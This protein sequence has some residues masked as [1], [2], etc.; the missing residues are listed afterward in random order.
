MSKNK[1]PQTTDPSDPV[2]MYIIIRSSLNLRM[3]KACAQAGHAV[4]S[5]M[6]NMV[7]KPNPQKEYVSLF[8]KWI[9]SDYRKIVLQ[10]SE[11]QWLKI[12]EECKDYMVVIVDAGLT[13]VP[14]GTETC[15]GL[16]PMLKSKIPTIIKGL[17]AL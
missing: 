17:Q 4:S 14:S 16:Y 13:Q 5:V 2:A 11:I 10:A 8:S 12:K 7:I 3:G 1:K 6:E 15:I 9:S